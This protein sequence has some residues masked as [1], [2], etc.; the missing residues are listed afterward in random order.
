[1]QN[2]NTKIVLS[3]IHITMIFNLCV[4]ILFFSFFY[5]YAYYIK[6]TIAK[7]LST[8]DNARFEGVSQSLFDRS[9]SHPLDWDE[10]ILPTTKPY[11]H[12]KSVIIIDLNTG[13]ILYEN[14]ADEVIPPAS[15]TKVAAMYVV[16]EEIESG[17]ISLSDY[18]PL[19]PEAWSIN[20]PPESSLMF[21]GAGHTVT[22]Q[23]VLLGLN[24]SS[25][26]DA[27]VAVANYVSGSMEQFIER[28]NEVVLEAGLTQTRFFDSSG[29][30]AK[31]TTTAREFAK[32]ARLYVE[33]YPE[34]LELFHTVPQIAYPQEHNLPP[35]RIGLDFPIVQ[36]NTNPTI[37][38]IDGVTG[39]KTGFIDESG[40]NLSLTVERG[41]TS[42]LSVIMGGPGRNSREGQAYRLEDSI[43]IVD[44]AYSHFKTA[45][46]ETSLAISIPVLGGKE[47]AVLAR[48][49][50]HTGVTVPAS[51]QNLSRTVETP[52]YAESP[53]RIGDVLGYAVYTADNVE[54]QKVPLL[55]D[56]TIEK[57]ISLYPI[58]Y[59]LGL[60]LS[61]KQ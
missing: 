59:L 8:L 36:K 11:I 44:Y 37:G 53:V 15:M 35:S 38:V 28:M 30:S 57:S 20:A 61:R 39:L 16:F 31:N 40:F 58:E 56:R 51:A 3:N 24:I 33:K 1:M 54:V 60:T 41:N 6:T 49:A 34:T 50:W 7:P 2:K 32:F 45:G 13:S 4:W 22:L 29:Y 43:S 26:N 9:G 47:N 18:V 21:L 42:I 55:A 46:Y 17:R 23:E 52:A 48:E 19:P 25:G 10:S 12:A 14:N 27:A 5:G